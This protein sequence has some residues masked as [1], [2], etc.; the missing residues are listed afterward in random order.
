R[1]IA[2]A[3]RDRL[4]ERGLD[5]DRVEAEEPGSLDGVDAVVLGSAVYAGHWV[6]PARDFVDRFRARLAEMP[7]WIFSSG[8]IGD[9]P[10]PDEEPVDVEEVM[11]ATGAL[12]HAVFAGA[13]DKSKL[14]FGERAIVAA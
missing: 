9:P 2:D 10:K 6:R 12:G 7:V 4:V 13:L 14:G 5:A 11:T 8:P 3:I 1:G